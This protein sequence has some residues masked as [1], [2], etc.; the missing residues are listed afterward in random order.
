MG[1]CT[2]GIALLVLLAGTAGC[3]DPLARVAARPTPTG[4]AVR[5]SAVAVAQPAP[6]ERK[7]GLDA[8]ANLMC[9]GLGRFSSDVAAARQRRAAA[10]AGPP[11]AGRAGLTAYYN[12]L[13]TA[14]GQ[15]LVV[16]RSAGIPDLRNGAAV[17]AGVNK[18]IT[19]AQ[20]AGG[21]YRSRV[22]GLTEAHEKS[23]RAD[24]E[25]I[26]HDSDHDLAGAM[27]GLAR[28]D[29]DPAFRAAFDHARGCRRG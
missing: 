14:F 5:A 6:T 10:L 28:F 21:T 25:R 2:A 11:A 7:V 8:Y 13:D 29:A 15:L 23:F 16:S 19:Q 1:R 22:R 4:Q 27:H 26:A 3:G 9:A 12:A 20:Q 17:A 18:T 24:A